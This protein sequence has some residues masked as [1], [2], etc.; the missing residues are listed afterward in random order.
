MHLRETCTSAAEPVNSQYPDNNFEHHCRKL[1]EALR[2]LQSSKAPIH[3]KH[4]TSYELYVAAN[5]FFAENDRKKED[6]FDIETK[7]D[8]FDAMSSSMTSS[9]SAK[10]PCQ[11][12]L[13]PFHVYE[14]REVLLYTETK[15]RALRRQ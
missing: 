8:P 6:S 15:A 4:C 3:S 14:V 13:S 10:T 1:D 7:K 9:D 12:Y 5:A 2:D 11:A